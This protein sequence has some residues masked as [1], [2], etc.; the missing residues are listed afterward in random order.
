MMTNYNQMMGETF[1]AKG[2]I[3]L[4]LVEKPSERGGEAIVTGHGLFGDNCL[5]DYTPLA[6][7]YTAYVSRC[8][9]PSGPGCL[10]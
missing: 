2:I 5:Y 1:A 9:L 4:P 7:I 3:T 6:Y 10:E 8:A